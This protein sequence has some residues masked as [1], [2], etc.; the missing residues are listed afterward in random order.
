MTTHQID[1]YME[2]MLDWTKKIHEKAKG[3]ISDAQ[4]KQK[5]YFDTP[6]TYI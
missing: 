5:K 3:N 6:T 1:E 2:L 4:K